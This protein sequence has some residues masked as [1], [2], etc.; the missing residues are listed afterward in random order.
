MKY[1]VFIFLFFQ[2]ASADVIIYDYQ[3]K[4]VVLDSKKISSKNRIE[5]KLLN[6]PYDIFIIGKKNNLNNSLKKLLKQFN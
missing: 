5:S 1:L 3:N 4:K 2:F 6:G